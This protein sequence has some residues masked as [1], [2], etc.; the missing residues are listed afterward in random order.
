[1][2]KRDRRYRGIRN[3]EERSESKTAHISSLPAVNKPSYFSEF[4]AN[5]AKSLLCTCTRFILPLCQQFI[6]VKPSKHTKV[7]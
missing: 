6:V 5:Q 3:N 4:A 7:I 1:M 2:P